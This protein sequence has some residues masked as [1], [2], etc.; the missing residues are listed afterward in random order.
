MEFNLLTAKPVLYVANV[1]EATSSNAFAE[2]V[3]ALAKKNGAS[4][5]VINAKLEADIMALPEEERASFRTA[6]GAV[7]SGIDALAKAGEK[8]LDLIT[9]FAAGPKEA[10]AWHVKRGSFVPQAAGKIHSDMEK[11]FI[12]AEIYSV[13]DLEEARSEAALRAKGKFRMEGRDYIIQDGDVVHIH[14]KV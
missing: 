5:V 9:F 10:H 8:L 3:G 7:D 12:R 11:G 14:F 6:M 13:A 4:M 1:N 2:T